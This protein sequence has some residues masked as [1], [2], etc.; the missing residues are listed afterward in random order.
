V[1]LWSLVD[2]GDARAVRAISPI[3][4]VSE[5]GTM[6]DVFKGVVNVDIRDS[7]PDWGPFEPPKAPMMAR[8]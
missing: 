8:E 4:H 1:S 2:G 7:V 5:A 6:S 3:R